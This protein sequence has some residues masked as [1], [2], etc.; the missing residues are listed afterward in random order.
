[1]SFSILLDELYQIQSKLATILGIVD[2][3]GRDYR[4]TVCLLVCGSQCLYREGKHLTSGENQDR[5][6]LYHARIIPEPTGNGNI[7]LFSYKRPAGVLSRYIA[8]DAI[9]A[10]NLLHDAATMYRF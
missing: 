6:L 1:M 5:F 3:S 8:K 9:L 10:Y 7:Q 2:Q 4:A